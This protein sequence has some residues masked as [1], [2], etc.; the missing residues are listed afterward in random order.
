MSRTIL[1][2]LLFGFVT[3]LAQNDKNE[4]KMTVAE[5]ADNDR[6]ADGI[7]NTHVCVS[8]PFCALAFAD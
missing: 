1:Q 5:K 7:G 2:N 8:S 3:R 4:N 6:D